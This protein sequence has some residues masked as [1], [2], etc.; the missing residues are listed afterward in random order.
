VKVGN[1]EKPVVEKRKAE[2]EESSGFLCGIKKKGK[3]KGRGPIKK[4][5]FQEFLRD[6]AGKVGLKETRF[7][8]KGKSN[9]CTYFKKERAAALAAG[10]W[11]KARASKKK[12]GKREERHSDRHPL[13]ESNQKPRERAYPN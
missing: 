4:G 9:Q 2:A 8:E 3:K 1:G 10:D 6:Y 5:E 11:R 12:L 13:E 7:A